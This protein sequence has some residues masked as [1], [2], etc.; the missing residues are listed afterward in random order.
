M[1]PLHVAA[2]KGDRFKIVKYL[3]DSGAR[4]N[5]QDDNGVIVLAING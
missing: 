5:I 2:E 3:V 1:A 4:I